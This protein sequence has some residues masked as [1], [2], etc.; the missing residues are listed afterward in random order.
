M[1][2][3]QKAKET[4][5]MPVVSPKRKPKT[6]IYLISPKPNHIPLEIKNIIKNGEVRTIPESKD[7]KIER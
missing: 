6:A 4:A 1:A 5:E 7:V 3:I 2:P